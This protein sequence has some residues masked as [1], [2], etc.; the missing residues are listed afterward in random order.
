MAGVW[1][2]RASTAL[3]FLRPKNVTRER[4]IALLPRLLIV[5]DNVD[6]KS[7]QEEQGAGST[8]QLV[9]I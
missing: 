4:P 7:G 6:F 8:V 3:L 1:R 9:V 5:M 2:E